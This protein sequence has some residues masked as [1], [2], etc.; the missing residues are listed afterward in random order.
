MKRRTQFAEFPHFGSGPAPLFEVAHAQPPSHPVVYFGNRSVIFRYSEAVHPAPQVF[1]KF[2]IPI[3]HGDEPGPAGQFLDL[4]FE[5][6]EGLLRPVNLGPTEGETEK[7]SLICRDDTALLLVDPEFEM[8]FLKTAMNHYPGAQV[9]S[10]EAK[11]PFVANL[12]R[13]PVHQDFV[14][15][16]IEKH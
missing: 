1:G 14:I 6:T 2:L 11:D 3:V 16:H 13:N 12:S 10:D 7:G 9:F 4:S 5:F 15:D 8:T